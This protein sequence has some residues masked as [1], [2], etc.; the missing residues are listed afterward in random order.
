MTRDRTEH[1]SKT[2]TVAEIAEMVDGRSNGKKNVEITGASGIREAGEGDLTFVAHPRYMPLVKQTK[3]AA[4]MV[5]KDLD[6]DES[7]TSA[8]FIRVDDPEAAFAQVIAQ[9]T[10]EEMTFEP[11]I[12][13]AAVIGENV[14][15]GKDVVIQACAVICDGA[16]VGDN[17]VI[18][19]GVY[20]GHYTRIG[21]RCLIYPGVKI[22]ERI[23]IGSDV[24]IH[25][26]TVIG[27][28]GFGFS[29]VKGVHHKIPQ[30]G[31]VEIED[32]VEIGANVTIDRARFDKT[33]IGKGTKI[34]NLV[35]IAHNVWIGEHCLIV[36]QCGVAGSTRV[37]NNVVIAAQAGIDGHIEVGDNVIIVGKAGVTKNVP[38]GTV[39]SGFPAQVRDKHR[40][41]QIHLR[42]LP[43][44]CVRIKELEERLSQ[45]EKAATN[46]SK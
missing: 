23:T 35:Q 46:H 42:R 26:G 34:D 24:I 6:I 14:D 15:L 31:T 8:A 25:S 16:A 30:L 13:P 44:Y 33:H 21:R 7:E 41:E 29:T 36:A 27:S 19:P 9:F 20:V 5:G 17:T 38:S 43:E 40:R 4:I 32:D 10:G 18:Y 1:K 37:G 45:L 39:V 22:R 28:D 11:G 2:W 3:A 12:H